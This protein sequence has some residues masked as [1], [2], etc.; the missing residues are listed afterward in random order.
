MSKKDTA[1]AAAMAATGKFFSAKP[2]STQETHD[3]HNKSEKAESQLPDTADLT[4]EQIA[5]IV[6][7]SME[8][9]QSASPKRGRP[10]KT[11]E[12]KLRGY[13]YN[14]N[15]DRDLQQYLKETAWKKR[16]SI[17]QYINDL[18]RADMEAYFRECEAAGID[19]REGWEV[20]E[21]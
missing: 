10:K 17:T 3:T 11:D 6:Q 19:P 9:L 7:H 5:S 16:T 12:E 15:L 4:P 1:K 13:R 8:I 2:Q 14:L 18:I 21:P 20:D